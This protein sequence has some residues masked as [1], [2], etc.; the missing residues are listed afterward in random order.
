M[1]GLKRLP[2]ASRRRIFTC[3]LVCGE[4][5]QVCD[6]IKACRVIYDSARS[7]NVVSGLIGWC[8]VDQDILSELNS[9]RLEI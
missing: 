1:K 8:G 7:Q 3:G 9:I 2:H 4:F 6:K 5:K